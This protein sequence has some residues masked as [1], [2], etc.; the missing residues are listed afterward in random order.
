M[1]MEQRLATGA[2]RRQKVAHGAS[3]FIR[4]NNSSPGGAKESVAPSGAWFDA[5]RNPT[6]CAEGY[7]L[8]PHRG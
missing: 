8:P 3:G 6:A 4:E 1:K 5:I 7:H 2:E